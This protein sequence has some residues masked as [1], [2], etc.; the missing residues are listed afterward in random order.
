MHAVARLARR[1][2]RLVQRIAQ[3]IALS[4]KLLALPAQIFDGRQGLM[5]PATRLL[6]LR[7]ALLDV[8][9]YLLGVVFQPGDA[10]PDLFGACL[11]ATE[12]RPDLGKH[13]LCRFHFTLLRLTRL[14][15]LEQCLAVGRELFGQLLDARLQFRLVLHEI[16]DLAFAAQYARVRVVSAPQA[17]P[18]ATHLQA[19]RGHQRLSR[20]KVAATPQRL[21]QI[22]RGVD[23]IQQ[24]GQL[25]RTLHLLRQGPGARSHWI[26]VRFEQ[27]QHAL[28]E[29]VQLGA[30]PIQLVDH[31][32]LQLPG[33]YHFYRRL[34]LIRHL[35]RFEQAPRLAEALDIQPTRDD[36]VAF[37]AR[38]L[39]QCLQRCQPPLERLQ[40]AARVGEILLDLLVALPQPGDRLHPIF[41]T[42][43]HRTQ[44]G[45]ALRFAVLQFFDLGLQCNIREVLTF[46]LVSG[47]PAFELHLLLLEVIDPRTLHL[48][49]LCRFVGALVE[50]IPFG[51]PG[52]H[53]LF[54]PLQLLRRGVG[55]GTGF[56]EHRPV[57]FEFVGE[58]RQS[59]VVLFAQ[60]LRLGQR[61]ACLGEVCLLLPACVP[62]VLDRV[63]ETGDLRASRVEAPLDIVES[64]VRLGM[65]R[66]LLFDLCFE[67]ALLGDRRLEAVFLLRDHPVALLDL[68]RHLVQT[69]YQQLG[70]HTPLFVAQRLVFLCGRRLPFEV[71]Q[72]FLHLFAQIVESLK[73]FTGVGDARFGLAPS[74]LVFGYPRRF[75]EVY[76]QVLGA[77]LDD[78]RDHALFDDR[79]AARP[80]AG[81]EK[82]IGDVTAATTYAV[83][84]VQR[85]AVARHLT[86]YRDLT[87]LSVLASRAAVRVVEQQF[88]ARGADRFA[89]ARTVEDDI[90]HRFAAQHLRRTLTHDPA[91]RVDDVGLAAAIGSNDADEITGEMHG[92]RVDKGFEARQLDLFQ[93][94]GGQRYRMREHPHK[95]PGYPRASLN[96]AA[97]KIVL[98]DFSNRTSSSLS[99]LRGGADV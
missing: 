97:Q 35:H 42:F 23:S 4:D 63:F 77:C 40:F 57:A 30:V 51:L 87:V 55:L 75:L 10:M 71:P 3:G 88:D 76:T 78:A 93:T 13:T 17:D 31:H 49:L 56:F 20:C 53:R 21:S 95:R 96:T 9:A 8:L 1:G 33:E 61:L 48:R 19:V 91:H 34:P 50:S 81:A 90:G 28:L 2:A 39:L 58:L 83:Q 66:A 38:G 14:L 12:Q 45:L 52:L 99:D 72:L 43:T 26:A 86:L 70:A 73:V 36:L 74:L 64:V 41:D 22:G 59:A 68:G 82:Q 62:G 11:F 65:C 25:R 92:G 16:T 27:C 5:Q 7:Q 89:A 24:M 84:V 85:L 47:Q 98:A 32:R 94:H 67:I 60:R 29:R 54:G 80:Q 44:P 6:H 46:L 18:T 79:I 15:G 69:Q 37:A